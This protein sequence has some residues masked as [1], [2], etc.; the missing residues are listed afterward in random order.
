MVF[1]LGSDHVIMRSDE[2]EN[3]QIIRF[4][5]TAREYHLRSA[6]AQQLGNRFA[7]PLYRRTRMLSVMMDGRGI[8]ELLEVIGTHG[9]K[10]FGQ[11][12]RGR[13]AVE[14]HPFHLSILG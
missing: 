1:N 7:C 10:H 3:S 13:V 5:T 9:F 4:R 12:R 6:A 2:T 11:N 8:A 14:I